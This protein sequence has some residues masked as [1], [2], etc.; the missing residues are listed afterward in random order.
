MPISLGVAR[1]KISIDTS[2]V[3]KARVTTERESKGI[4]AALKKA[5]EG[6][7]FNSWYKEAST[8][9]KKGG[10]EAQKTGITIK[11]SFDDSIKSLE[12]FG[13]TASQIGRDFAPIS[14]GA[15]LIAGLGL[16]TA[17][18][19]ENLNTKF[20]S[21]AGSQ[22]RA[23]VLMK[24][25]ADSAKKFN[26]PV[27]ATQQ[28]FAGLVPFIGQSQ[29]ALNQY[30][31][32][33]A[34]LQV[35]N[36]LATTEDAV[37][38][39]REALSSGGTDL[40]SLAE[41]FNLPKKRLREL[42]EQTGD[43][44]TAISILLD[45]MGATEEAAKEIG[46]GF[47]GSIKVAIDAIN[48]LLAAGFKPLIEAVTPL[49][50]QAAD[51]VENLAKQNP[52]LLKIGAGFAVIL[53]AV[54]PVALAV[55]QLVSLFS[56]LSKLDIASKI[57]SGLG[58]LKTATGKLVT[59][60]FAGKEN[61]MTAGRAV[62]IGLAVT[63][64]VELG[65]AG[66]RGLA[67]LGV[68][69]PSLKNATQ[70]EAIAKLWERLGQILIIFVDAI[71]NAATIIGKAKELIGEAFDNI[72]R[73]I[74]LAGTYVAEAFGSVVTRIGDV[75]VGLSNLLRDA[76][77]EQ[78]SIQLYD[79][80]MAARI[81]GDK[82][83]NAA[84]DR[85]A[86]LEE[87]LKPENVGAR[88]QERFQQV[89]DSIKPARDQM[90]KSITNIFFPDEAAK[91]FG[92]AS[93]AFGV[94]VGTFIGNFINKGKEVV[95]KLIE[96]TT[97]NDDQ[98][99][100][101]GKYAEDRQAIIDKANED[102]LDARKDHDENLKKID[103]DADAD[104][105]AIHQRAKDQAAEDE[106][107][108]QDRRAEIAADAKDRAAEAEQELQDKRAQIA[109]QTAEQIAAEEASYQAD[110]A[111]IITDAQKADLKLVDDYHKAK[112][113]LERDHR[114]ALA[115][116]A[117]NLDAR[118]VAREQDQFGSKNKELD[119]KLKEDRDANAKQAAERLAELDQEH[120]AK[121]AQIQAA[122]AKELNEFIAQQQ[123]KE[124]AQAA[125]DAKDLEKLA[126]QQKLRAERQAAADVAEIAQ[127]NA[128]REQEKVLEGQAFTQRLNQIISDKNRELQLREQKF[129]L[130]F[131]QLATHESQKL[132]I[133]RQY[134]AATELELRK[135]WERQRAMI[136]ATPARA[137]TPPRSA[138]PG[139]GAGPGFAAG[140]PRIPFD[141][142]ARVHQSEGILSAPVAAM[143]RSLL[144][145][146]YTQPQMAGLL[147]GRGQAA[148]PSFAW[149]G[150]L[151]VG[152]IGDRSDADVIGLVEEGLTRV[153]SKL[154]NKLQGQP[155]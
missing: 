59:D 83:Q 85:R 132:G 135:W 68:G 109:A 136:A 56:T 127:I 37:F 115:E 149:S 4:S 48:R 128:K 8:A 72:G 80:G 139:F 55:G 140:T 153:V 38:S 155:S 95:T 61:G 148:A 64:G 23:D 99:A 31:G 147:A 22:A 88:L 45:E 9:F 103:A 114:L 6:G 26:L 90:L 84:T 66:A 43:F 134:Q 150:N 29:A 33:A 42:V 44:A 79:A 116:A 2:D 71:F 141:M 121:L 108:L 67:N 131:D 125:S 10:A 154:A 122:G 5:G 41:R 123:K 146:N 60:F 102:E 54:T 28:S 145:N 51:A 12:K 118:A 105:E 58:G 76:G 70:E 75:L 94:Q 86:Q 91:K 36:P 152:D 15:G 96:A 25:L 93:E 77:L 73:Q 100:A 3:S 24:N 13:K 18:S 65:A 52:D 35:L 21:L 104:I 16:K 40:V 126:A 81:S 129:R 27:L 50:K 92:E 32:I 144:G 133:Q 69:D 107:E 138:Q 17:G 113:K 49:L 82:T 46:G 20:K 137:V 112:E 143:A 39:L 110:H 101:Y 117:S 14:I 19:I 89:D 119:D 98:I 74:E 151:V 130:E 142:T 11:R 1:G 97:F 53:A 62:G 78:Q 111:K 57:V 7:D 124:Q 34:R 106:Q 47:S 120:T 87:E 63:G 30:I